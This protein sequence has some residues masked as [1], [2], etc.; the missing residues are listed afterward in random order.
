MHRLL[1]CIAK[2]QK[3]DRSQH[4]RACKKRA[5]E[6]RD[7]ILFKQPESSHMGDCP[8]CF[9][10]LSISPRKSNTM[11]C[12][13]KIICRGCD[14]A[15]LIRELVG[16]LEWKCPFSFCRQPTPDSDEEARMKRIEANDPVATLD[17]GLERQNEGDYE[18]AHRY[19]TK[20]A[21]LGDAQSHYQLSCLYREGKG[22]DKDEK[23]EIRHL[24]QAAIG[25][26]PNARHNLGCVEA[27]NGKTERAI[28]HII[29]AAN[30]GHDGSLETAEK[31]YA[32][33]MISKDVFDKALRTH[34]AAVDATK[35]PQREEAEVLM[36]KFEAAKAA[37]QI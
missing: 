22:V 17:M 10:P 11:A 33:G 7:E 19:Y 30:M 18:S 23:K 9:L 13:S 31:F 2:C 32:R 3:E 36:K 24:E 5:A 6:L 34:H 35:S 20:S 8:I 21:A 28:Q 29:I 14:I 16:C 25:G 26:D 15:N 12:C 4:E 1:S 37:G 27:N